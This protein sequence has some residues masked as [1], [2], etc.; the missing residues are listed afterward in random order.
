MRAYVYGA[1]FNS[2]ANVVEGR[3]VGY[4]VY[5]EWTNSGNTPAIEL[6]SWIEAHVIEFGFAQEPFQTDSF[7]AMTGAVVGPGTI[8]RTPSRYLIPIDVLILDWNRT[9]AVYLLA[10]VEYKDVFQ[11]EIIHHH[12]MCVR[13]EM[14]RDPRT[15]PTEGVAS[16]VRF[17]TFGPRNTSD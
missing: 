14:G 5:V 12:E 4:F 1:A 17:T 3:V 13:L 7:G 10:R 2:E 16:W 15:I 8:V 11:P 9:H 6:K